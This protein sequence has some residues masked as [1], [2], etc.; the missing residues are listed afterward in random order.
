MGWRLRIEHTTRVTYSGPVLTSFNEAR[1][2]PLTLPT[3]TTMDARVTAGPGAP[4]WTYND[5][6]GSYVSVF[7]LPEA[8]DEL[9]ILRDRDGGDRAV[10]RHPR[11]ARAPGLGGAARAGAARPA[12]R[13][14]AADPADHGDGGRS[15][16]RP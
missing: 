11:R 5:Y 13:V 16:T 14:P 10:S 6:W 8:H 2:T 9:L 7:D 15:S 1:M 3:Q 4:V 12:A